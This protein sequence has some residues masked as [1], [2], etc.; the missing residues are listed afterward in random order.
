MKEPLIIKLREELD[1]RIAQ[2]EAAIASATQSRNSDT[3]SSAGDKFETSREM[4]QQEIN[5]Y[6]QQL[7]QAKKQRSDLN[8]LDAA[9]VTSEVE[10]GSLIKTNTHTYFLAI[11]FGRLDFN[12]TPVFC[13]ST[14]AP[15]ARVMLGKR[16]GEAFHWQGKSHQVMDL[17]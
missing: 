3:K 1:K 11:P 5:R 2:F 6:E 7:A 14:A 17:T 12:G 15:V 13:I 16:I 9:R 4:A 10:L 8:G